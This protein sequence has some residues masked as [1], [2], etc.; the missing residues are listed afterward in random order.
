MKKTILAL[1]CLMSIL[2][3]ADV[4]PRIYPSGL[5]AGAVAGTK[6]DVSYTLNADATLVEA[7]LYTDAEVLLGTVAIPSDNDAYKTGRHKVTIDMGEYAATCKKWGIHAVAA[8]VTTLSETTVSSTNANNAFSYYLPQGAVVDNNPKSPYFGQLYVTMPWPGESDGGCDYT[9]V[10]KAGLYL[11]DPMLNLLNTTAYDM[12]IQFAK[13]NRQ[14]FKRVTVDAQGFVYVNDNTNNQIYKINPADFT[15]CQKLLAGDKTTSVNSLVVDGNYMYVLDN[16]STAGGKLIRFTLDNFGTFETIVQ[17]T[18]WANSDNSLAPDGKGGIWV[19]QYR[20][21]VDEYNILTHVNAKGTI[22]FEVNSSSDASLTSCFPSGTARGQL[23]INVKG[24]LLAVGGSKT[25]VL[26][27]VEYD[28][29][30]KPTLTKNAASF[31]AFGN[32]ID[33]LAFDIADNLFILSASVERLYVYPLPGEKNEFTVIAP[34]AFGADVTAVT[35]VTLSAET[36]TIEEGSADI[37][38]ATVTPADASNKHVIWSSA[39]ETIATVTNGQVTGVGAGQTTITVTT[40]DGGFTA[41]CAVTITEKAK[42]YPNIMAYAL[43]AAPT[44]NKNEYTFNYSLNAPATELAVVLSLTTLPTGGSEPE[45]IRLAITDADALKRGAH[46]VVMT[47]N[48]VNVGEYNWAV[49]AKAEVKADDEAT[50]TNVFN[51]R[52]FSSPRGIAVNNNTESPFFGNVYVTESAGGLEAGSGLYAF[53]PML[54]SNDVVYSSG[55]SASKASPM[56]VTIGQDDDMLYITDWSDG[57]PN[58][59]VLDQANPT[60]E[61]LIFG[62]IN[63]TGGVYVAADSTTQIHGSMSSCYV[64]GKGA[65]RVLYTFDEDITAPGVDNIMTLYRYDIG[66]L[67][68]PW[69]AAPSAVVYKNTENYERNGNS[70]I[71]PDAFGGWWISQDRANDEVA[72][73]ALIHINKEGAVDW[74][75]NGTFGGRTR[76]AL[77]LNEEQ[78][79]LVSA[80]DNCLRVWDVEFDPETGAPE[81]ALNYPIV[82]TFGA[83]NSSSC[84]SLA[85]DHALNV[86]ATGDGKQLCVWALI[87]EENACTTKAASTSVITVEYVSGLDNVMSDNAKMHGVYSITGQYLGEDASNLQKGVYIVNGEKV[88]K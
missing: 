84:Y 58:V 5:T 71:I 54:K 70:V 15:T 45:P 8:D 64:T 51:T 43:S 52:V 59:H 24:N 56:R 53:D 37:L 22:D 65:D 7:L 31:P 55:W 77:A 4:Q 60:Q 29:D 16:A 42:F 23:A 74:T 19:A 69:T 80:G 44:S 48:D 13:S 2:T 81:V 39:D 66:E 67:A 40:E 28:A 36:L 50:E 76:G 30:G 86:Y 32:N 85:V 49:E 57:E 38:T 1:F 18:K 62:G 82:T 26:Y 34:N 3:F 6:V 47:L 79:V 87:K 88:I 11:Y 35:G 14:Q 20:G 68:E 72:I 27:D 21:T 78:T 75:S 33:G 17:S 46:S 10:Q 25:V 63:T 61:S 83:Q 73:P 41:T 12:G 9:K